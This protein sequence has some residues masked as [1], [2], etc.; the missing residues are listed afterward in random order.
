MLKGGAYDEI[1]RAAIATATQT[2]DGIN[3]QA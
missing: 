3:L 2:G 1:L